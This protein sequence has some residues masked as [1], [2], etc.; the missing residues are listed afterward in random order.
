MKYVLHKGFL[1]QK[2]AETE[3]PPKYVRYKDATYALVEAALPRRKWKY[4]DFTNSLKLPP[5][6]QQQWDVNKDDLLA[7][8]DTSMSETGNPHHREPA[9]LMWHPVS[10]QMLI[11]SLGGYGGTHAHLAHDY[12]SHDYDEY[13]RAMIYPDEPGKRLVEI[14]AWFPQA[15]W[16]M[17]DSDF[18][19]LCFDGQFALKS[20]LEK[21]GV[22]ES[23]FSLASCK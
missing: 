18:A 21:R 8:V 13:V 7:S 20:L 6:L 15:S 19:T 17:Y 9:L 11:A 5:Q 16:G 10:G 3:A 22:K 2:V 4:S 1:Y 23:E 12:G 14:Y